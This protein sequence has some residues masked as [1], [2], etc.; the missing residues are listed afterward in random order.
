MHEI[1]YSK[2]G[3]VVHYDPETG[4][5]YTTDRGRLPIDEFDTISSFGEIAHFHGLDRD[6]TL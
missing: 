2:A 4:E 1:L 5:V 6:A 3:V